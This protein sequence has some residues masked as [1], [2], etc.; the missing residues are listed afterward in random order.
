MDI[1]VSMKVVNLFFDRPAVIRRLDV[2]NHRALSKAGAYVRRAAMSR[3]R[4]R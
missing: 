4:R 1:T 2:A 3:L